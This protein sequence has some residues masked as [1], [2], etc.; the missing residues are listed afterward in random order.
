M[1]Q[2]RIGLALMVLAVSGAA[3]AR[4]APRARDAG[5]ILRRRKSLRYL[6]IARS[7]LSCGMIRD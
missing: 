5:G 4:L 2:S 7:I 6:P 1:K 3:F